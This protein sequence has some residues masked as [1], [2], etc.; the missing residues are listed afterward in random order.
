[1]AHALS[2]HEAREMAIGRAELAACSDL[3]RAFDACEIDAEINTP[4]WRPESVP[5]WETVS[6]W[7]GDGTDV[8]TNERM[9]RIVLALVRAAHSGD[10]AIRAASRS[11]LVDVASWHGEQQGEALVAR[12]EREAAEDGLEPERTGWHDARMAPLYPMD[13]IDR[14]AA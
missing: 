4:A 1:M 12:D 7:I 6:E 11:V 8:T 9:R 3:H 2:E 5:A 13:V 14:R 10:L